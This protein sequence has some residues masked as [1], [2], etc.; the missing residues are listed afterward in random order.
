MPLPKVTH[1]VCPT[2][3]IDKSYKEFNKTAKKCRVCVA[4]G[5]KSPRGERTGPK[6]HGIV[7]CI[8]CGEMKQF[9]AK[10]MCDACWQTARIE[11]KI[12]EGTY[13]VPVGT[14]KMCLNCKVVKPIDQFKKNKDA[15]DGL[16]AWCD[17]C[18]H[19]KEKEYRSDPNWV[20]SY[21]KKSRE[22]FSR[23]TD[24][25]KRRKHEMNYDRQKERMKIDPEYR[26]R[27]NRQSDL[28]NRRR[29]KILW[30]KEEHYTIEEWVALCEKYDNR[31]VSCKQQ[32]GLTVD[33]VVPL[34]QGGKD[35]IDN[36][37]P[38]CRSCNSRK[39][40]RHI[41]YR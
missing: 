7:K 22:Y 39:N 4:A 37:Q 29:E 12:A 8:R 20:S 36:I 41:D 11:R 21:Q 23:M 31:C 17:E 5:I 30:S 6:P 2:C 3:H 16:Q 28:K 34:S 19:K 38:L 33:H 40:D 27:K 10:G 14:E 32:I 13:Y 25:Q 1:R 18:R 24:E 9:R 15:R 35:T 26:N